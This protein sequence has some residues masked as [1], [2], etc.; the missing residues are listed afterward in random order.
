MK[1]Y[2]CGVLVANVAWSRGGRL[3]INT[4]EMAR[5]SSWRDK[6]RIVSASYELMTQPLHIQPWRLLQPAIVCIVAN[7]IIVCNAASNV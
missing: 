1:S 3:F 2:Q 4:A 6:W 5:K 7:I